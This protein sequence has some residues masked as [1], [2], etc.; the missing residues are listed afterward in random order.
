MLPLSIHSPS[1]PNSSSISLVNT[2]SMVIR[3]VIASV[4]S[5]AGL[6]SEPAFKVPYSDLRSPAELPLY[7]LL[8]VLCG[9]VS[10]TLSKCTSYMLVFVDNLHKTV[11]L[12][13][14]FFPIVGGLAIGLMALAY[15]EILYQGFKNVDILLESRPLRK[16]SQLISFFSW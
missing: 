9:L 1:P 8:G 4:V 10:L 5:E 2:T 7:L 6:C 11:G 15:P 13:K 16:A 14:F 12:P 3:A